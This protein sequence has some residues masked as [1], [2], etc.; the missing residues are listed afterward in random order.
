MMEAT[1]LFKDARQLAS[2]LRELRKDRR[3][4]KLQMRAEGRRRQSLGSKGRRAVPSKTAGRCHICGG[5]IDGDWVADNV[6]AHAQGGAHSVDNYLPAHALCNN[7][8]WFY[9]TEEFQW[10][11]KLGVW[12][13][14]RIENEDHRTLELVEEFVRHEARRHY[15]RKVR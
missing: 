13:R 5:A 11:L 4:R 10:I 1:S 12:L 15:R 6:L 8:R 2:H 7:Y 9:G 3:T 14:T